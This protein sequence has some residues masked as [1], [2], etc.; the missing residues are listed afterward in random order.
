LVCFVVFLSQQTWQEVCLVLSHN[1]EDSISELVVLNRPI[2]K[3]INKSLAKV[4]LE[5]TNGSGRNKFS[6]DFIDT[7]VQVFSKEAAVYMG[8]P[9]NIENPA[10]L[11]HGISNL[12][13]SYEIESGTKIYR[14]GIV[15]AVHG[16]QQ[17]LYNPLDFRFFI[18]Q[19]YYNPILF[20]QHGTIQQKI[21]NGSY[22]SIACAR[23]LALKQCLGL[24]KPLWHEGMF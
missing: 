24:P 3:S 11:I 15:A 5:G 10:I 2:S 8:G 14:D 12:P 9:H 20:P 1:V 22:Q 23:S 21:Q 19:Q 7:F 4:M 13:G 18:G 17:G 16:I 6:S